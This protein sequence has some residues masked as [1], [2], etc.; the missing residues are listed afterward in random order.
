METYL[1]LRYGS[2]KT[3]GSGVLVFCFGCLVCLRTVYVF[4]N[5]CLF[6]TVGRQDCLIPLDNWLHWLG[7]YVCRSSLVVYF[8][9]R[10]KLS[11]RNGRVGSRIMGQDTWQRE[12]A[13][14]NIECAFYGSADIQNCLSLNKMHLRFSQIRSQNWVSS[15]HLCCYLSCR[16]CKLL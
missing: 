14:R 12:M 5:S 2:G 10:E 11:R 16:S 4:F 8:W 1:H 15:L 9:D 13:R 7:A 6:I 3:E